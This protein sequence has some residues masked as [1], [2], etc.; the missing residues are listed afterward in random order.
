MAEEEKTFDLK[1]EQGKPLA[2]GKPSPITVEGLTPNTT[3]KGWKLYYA[4]KEA[5]ADVPEFKTLD[6]VPAKPTLSVKAGDAKIDATLTDGANEGSDVTKRQLVLSADGK[7]LTTLDAES[8]TAKTFTDLTNDKLYSVHAEVTNG[9]GV[10]KSDEAEATPKAPVVK[11]SS[12]TIDNLA[13]AGKAGQ[14]ATLTLS[15]INPENTTD[16]GVNV[17]V[18]DD[19][20]ATVT[21]NKDKTYTVNFLKEGTTKIHWVA[22]DGGGA[23]ADATVTVSASSTD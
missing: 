8:G 14:N 18:D 21:D 4:G 7:A 17:T 23:K 22:K 3:Y 9:A 2:E 15:T 11:M 1:D 16:K 19:K 6:V 20:V 10:V 12:F 5:G 13:P